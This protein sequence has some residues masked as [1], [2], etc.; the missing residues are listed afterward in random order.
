MTLTP[1]QTM[2]VIVA[3][4]DGCDNELGKLIPPENLILSLVNTDM[5]ENG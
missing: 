3:C 2:A 5:E 1:F 4:L